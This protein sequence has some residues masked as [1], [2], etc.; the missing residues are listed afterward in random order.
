MKIIDISKTIN[1]KLQLWPGDCE[2]ERN[3][4]EFEVDGN[5]GHVSNIVMSLHTGTHVDSH[6]HYSDS[7]KT[8][9]QHNLENY[10]GDCQVVHVYN[11]S[12]R[13]ITLEDIK[14]D[15][16]SKRILFRTYKS[17][18]ETSWDDNF[19]GLDPELIKYLSNKG[20]ILIGTDAP[21]VD[22]YNYNRFKTHHEFLNNNIY[23]LEGLN[24]NNVEEQS[25][26][27][28]AL[29]LKIEGADGSPV[30]AIL[31]SGEEY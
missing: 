2:L 24:L 22:A 28:V 3:E 19:K 5:I 1:S 12:N 25:Y 13:L 4:S 30:R 9:E 8:I 11:S 18:D 21:S 20:V 6:W 31:I 17:L 15:I 16:I 14:V 27:L 7:G 10:V 23:I 29:P 26:E